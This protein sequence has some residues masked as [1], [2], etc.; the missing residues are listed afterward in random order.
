MK[1]YNILILAKENLKFSYRHANSRKNCVILELIF[2]FDKGFD[3]AKVEEIKELRESKHP[4]DKSSLWV[5]L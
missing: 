3:K 1:N 2:K 4:L 5:A